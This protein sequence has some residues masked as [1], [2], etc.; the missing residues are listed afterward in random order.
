MTN[1]LNS[2]KAWHEKYGKH[3]TNIKRAITLIRMSGSKGLT[4]REMAA[5]CPD[6][7]EHRNCSSALSNAKRYNK[8]IELRPCE[9]DTH[10]RYH[11]TDRSKWTYYVEV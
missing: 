10:G 9:H 8:S 3:H 7:L 6:L 4:A 11:E 2:M 1:N 5:V